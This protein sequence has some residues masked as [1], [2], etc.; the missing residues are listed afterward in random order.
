MLAGALAATALLLAGCGSGTPQ[1]VAKASDQPSTVT[2]SLDLDALPPC[3][4]L[5][6]A[7]P[8]PDGLPDAPLDCLGAGPAVRL[9]DL[10]GT[11]MVLNVWAAW[12]PNCDQEMPLLA[13]AQR[14]AGT[15]LR[16]FGVHYKAPRDYGLR[17][18]ADFGVSFPSVHDE[19]GDLIVRD[20]KAYAP[21]QTFFVTADGR[22]AGHKIGEIRSAKE[23]AALIKTNLG[24]TL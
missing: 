5:P 4:E 2:G 3:P 23:L 20:L 19:D 22:I 7:T 18:A 15:K 10:R 11:P 13:A 8:R 17:S 14:K 1:P 6:R 12:C 9:S 21:P 16:F 24:V